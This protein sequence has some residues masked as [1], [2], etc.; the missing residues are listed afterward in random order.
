PRAG[1]G[2]V[3]ARDEDGAWF[4]RA[5]LQAAE[6][7]A[8]DEFGSA[9]AISGRTAAVGAPREDGGAA[10]I[11]GDA[12]SNDLS[13]AGA[14]YL[15][16]ADDDGNWSQIAYV[17]A[18]NV[19]AGDFFGASVALDGGRLAV[20]APGESSSTGDPDD[21]TADGSGAVYVFERDEAGV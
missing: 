1:D 7:N 13:A 12:S 16:E 9:V 8:G 14:V 4:Q 5:Y 11:D 3:G 18:S 6:S 15:F 19:D 17:K 10:G 20:G 2:Y 21:D